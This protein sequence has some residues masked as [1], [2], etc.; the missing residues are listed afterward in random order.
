[1]AKKDVF[2]GVKV[3][4]TVFNVFA[5]TVAEEIGMERTLALA[6][7]T[8]EKMGTMQGK[9]MKTQAGIKKSD[10]KT[11]ASLLTPV[12]ENLGV[13]VK[14]VEESPQRVVHKAIRCPMYAAAHE[15]GMDNKTIESMCRAGSITMMD[16]TVKQLNPKLSFHMLKFRSSPDDFC[17][18]E[19]VLG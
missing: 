8:M 19:I 16:A 4:G 12:I 2:N 14:I 11:S 5:Q 3:M 15:L 7:K 9:M 6:T 13:I 10:A 18:E 1:M 17:E